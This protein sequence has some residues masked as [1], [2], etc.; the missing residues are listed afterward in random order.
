MNATAGAAAAAEKPA[1]V[2]VGKVALVK[3]GNLLADIAAEIESLSKTKALNLADKLGEDIQAN[4][5]RLGGVLNLIATN[6]WFEGYKD[7]D[8]YVGEK[9]GMS[10]RTARYHMAIYT[11]LVAKQ[12]PWEKVA[13]LGWTKL[14]HL[15]PVIT[16]ENVDE[17]VKKAEPLT[18]N[19]LVAALK[20][21]S[22]PTGDTSPAT[23]D[24]VSV[25]KFKVKPDQKEVVTTALAKAKGELPTE[26]DNVALENICAGYIAGSAGVAQKTL[27][28]QMK[29]AG[30]TVVLDIFGKL[31]PTI[32]MKLEVPEGL[33]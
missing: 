27:E 19:E 6:S 23:K 24:D 13:H 3:T 28:E 31:W 17:W 2:A 4:T 8:T 16:L 7:F 21:G 9:F 10:I 1:T 20:A 30:W 14:I 11:D 33:K 29:A 18:V 5:F 25:L 32:D 22:T 26:Y 12:I 15:S